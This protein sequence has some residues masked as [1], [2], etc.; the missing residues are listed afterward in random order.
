MAQ[1]GFL[2][3]R[4]AP[5][6]ELN[7]R[8]F[9]SGLPLIVLHGFTGDSSTMADLAVQLRDDAA[10]V[11]P[12]LVGHGLSSAPA[13]EADYSVD[14]MVSHVVAIGEQLVGDSFHLVGYSMGGRVALALACRH[15]ELLRSL[16]VIGA[17]AGL[18]NESERAARR[19]A[20][21]DLAARIEREGM[22]RFV[23]TWMANPL[24]ATQ[25]RLGAEFL[26]RA[27]AQRLGNSVRA[28]ACS[29]RAAG[30]GAMAPLHA[31]LAEC[32]VPTVL[33]VGAQDP[34]FLRIA[35]ELV[36]LM[37]RAKLIRI[38]D[39]GHAAHLEQPVAVAAAIRAQLG[40]C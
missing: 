8:Q 2:R 33:V 36:P 21:H 40:V 11:V 35:S 22:A 39:A 1:N 26:E 20:D 3:L 14:H 30:S 31:G 29:L 37:P 12:D 19:A 6:V 4:V 15:P 17:S 24:F 32:G 9:G 10:L 7:V 34:K 13:N 25:T 5:E 27:R 18:A 16:T 23:D 28:L 38:G